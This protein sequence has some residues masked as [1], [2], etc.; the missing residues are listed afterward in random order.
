MGKR[1]RGSLRSGQYGAYKQGRDRGSVRRHVKHS[2][3]ESTHSPAV[4]SFDAY[5]NSEERNGPLEV[6]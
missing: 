6:P 4:P 2:A 5:R 1:E 3:S